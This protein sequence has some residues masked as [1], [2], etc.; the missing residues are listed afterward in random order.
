M[1]K[2]N[3]AIKMTQVFRIQSQSPNALMATRLLPF[4]DQK[5]LFA[6]KISILAT[7]W[8]M[9]ARNA[10]IAT[11]T[12]I[13]FSWEPFASNALSKA[14]HN[15][16]LSTTILHALLALMETKLLKV[17]LTQTMLCQ[18]MSTNALSV[19]RI[20][21]NVTLIKLASNASWVP[22][23]TTKLATSVQSLT[24]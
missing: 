4:Q 13:G 16:L 8:L 20:A 23:S 14:A 18:T 12:L 24:A 1:Q 7:S 2:L 10:R 11:L 17:L 22:C 6:F 9:R 3:I 19:V 21:A 15:A 5:N